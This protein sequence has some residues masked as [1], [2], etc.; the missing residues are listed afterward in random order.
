MAKGKSR[1]KALAVKAAAK[2][3]RM[4]NPGE[5]S[6]YAKKYAF[7]QRVGGFGFQYAEP[8]PWK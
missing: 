3:N 8:K 7:L 6:N 2:A 1:I 4:K 5:K